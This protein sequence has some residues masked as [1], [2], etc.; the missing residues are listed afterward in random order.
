MPIVLLSTVTIKHKINFR[1][2]GKTVNAK[3]I[4]LFLTVS[5]AEC[6]VKEDM[7]CL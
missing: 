7:H 2:E 6:S 3:V 1:T 4:N 5:Q